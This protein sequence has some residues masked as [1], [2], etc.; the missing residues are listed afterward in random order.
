MGVTKLGDLFPDRQ[1]VNFE[2]FSDKSVAFDGN[3]ILYQFLTRIRQSDGSL[4]TDEHGNVTSHLSGLLY[5]VSSIIEKGIKVVFIFDGKPPEEKTKEILKRKKGKKEADI[6]YEEALERGDMELAQRYAQRTARL[7]SPMINDAKKLLGLL[8][9][10]VVQAPSEGEGQAAYMAKKGDVWASCS[11]DYDSLLFGTPR[12]ARNLTIS[13]KRKLPRKN[14]YVE[15]KP[16]LID[17]EQSL[18]AI[19]LTREELIDLAI[20]LGT[21][22]NP[23]G[24]GMS[25]IGPKTALKLIKENKSIEKILEL[26][27]MSDATISFDIDNVRKIFLEPQITTDYILKWH[28]PKV[29]EIVDFLTRERGFSETR[30]RNALEKTMKRAEDQK[31]QPTL[32]S[33]FGS[34]KK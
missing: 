18:N 1:E 27:N 16:E 10:P 2:F 13:G 26:P 6:A 5:R 34:N 8:G 23:D 30:V 17:L 3:N 11:Q 15:V 33:F 29:D 22:F 14:V 21:D 28:P 9:V 4:L 7:T 12:L 24:I 25:G 19:E 20:I 32:D 31:K